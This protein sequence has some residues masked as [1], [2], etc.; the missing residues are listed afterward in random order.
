MSRQAKTVLRGALGLAV[1]A[2]VLDANP[3]NEVGRIESRRPARGAPSIST[4]TLPELLTGLR[5]SAFCTQNDLADPF[6]LLLATGMRRSELLAIRWVDINESERTVSVT[7]KVVRV[8]GGGLV[9]LSATKTESGLRTLKLP[10][11]AMEMLQRRAQEPTIGNLG[12]VFPSTVGTLRDPNNMGKQWRK[13][14]G[15]LGLAGVTTHSFRKTLATLIDDEGLSARVGADQLGHRQ[16]SM[17]QD[18]Y[19]SRGRQHVEVAN[20]LD[21]AVAK[22]DE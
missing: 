20:L 12:V 21:R 8:K 13:I 4:V 2:D 19:W 17:T 5:E 7:G 10:A 6:T 22:S 18:K 11:F 9:R 15:E 14:R 3:I 1:I 16:V